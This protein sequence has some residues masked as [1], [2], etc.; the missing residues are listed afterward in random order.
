MT[1]RNLEFVL[2]PRSIAVIGA[3]NNAGSVGHT[4][5]K[6]VIAGGFA[7]AVYLVN[8]KHGSIAGHDCFLTS[9]S[10]RWRRSLRSSQRRQGPF[11]PLSL[12]SERGARGLPSSSPPVLGMNL[13][14][15]CSM[16]RGQLVFVSSALIALV[17]GC[18]RSV[19]ANFGLPRPSPEGSLSCRNPARWSAACSTGRSARHRLFPCCVDGRHGRR[20]FRRPAGFPRRRLTTSAILLYL[21]TIPAARKFMSAAA[22]RRAPSR[23]SSSSPAAQGLG[24]SRGDAYRGA[25]GQ[26]RRGERLPPRRPRAGRRLEELFAAAETLTCLKPV[27]G[28]ELLILTNGGGAGVLAWTIWSRPAAAWPTRQRAFR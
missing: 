4:L 28:N 16:S 7:G 18:R 25:C 2:R 10:C 23:S 24:A 13:S 27:A 11:L 21:E 5:T 20:R 26:R 17:S 12:R 22:R 1:I 3:S 15:R 6:N 9:T 19:N 8:P 14:R